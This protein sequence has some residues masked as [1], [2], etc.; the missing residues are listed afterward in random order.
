MTDAATTANAEPGL[1]SSAQA[2]SASGP[3]AAA[4]EANSEARLRAQYSEIAQLA[5]GLAHEIRNPLSTMR[6]NLDLLAEE[7]QNPETQRDKR[8]LQKLD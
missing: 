7:F 3:P 2:S 5:G 6:L 4:S 1:E 8:V